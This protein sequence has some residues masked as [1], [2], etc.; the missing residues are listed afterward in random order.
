MDAAAYLETIKL[1]LAS[2]PVVRSVVIMQERSLPDQGFFRAR[3]TLQNDDFVEVTE[4]FV[5][6][7][8]RVRTVEYRYQWMDATQQM[9]R[10]RWDN[11]EHH[12]STPSFPHHVHVGDEDRVEP[13]RVLGIMELIGVIESEV[14]AQ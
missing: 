6:E 5:V 14:A 8:G 2:S 11:A 12:R 9:L 1:T 4:Y 10:K 7:R 3:L 13:G